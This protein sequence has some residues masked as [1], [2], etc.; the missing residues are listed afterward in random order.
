M[1]AFSFTTVCGCIISCS[2]ISERSVIGNEA[3]FTDKTAKELC[4]QEEEKEEEY[5]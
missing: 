3:Y 4:Q 1:M 2:F 5:V